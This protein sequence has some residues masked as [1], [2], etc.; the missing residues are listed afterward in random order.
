MSEDTGDL[1]TQGDFETQ[2]PFAPD[3]I[4]TVN[5]IMQARIY[6]VLSAILLELNED[7]A[8]N[9]LEMHMQGIIVGPSPQLNGVFV[10]DKLAEEQ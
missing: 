4:G 2:D 5:F 6:D 7:A 3:N 1:G 8:Q 9:L 10:A